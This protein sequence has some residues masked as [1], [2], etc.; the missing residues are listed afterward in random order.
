V[1]RWLCRVQSNRLYR[2]CQLN[3]KKK[4]G[5]QLW[6]SVILIKFWAKN[7]AWFFLFFNRPMKVSIFISMKLNVKMKWLQDHN[8]NWWVRIL[9][10]TS[11]SEDNY[12]PLPF[13]RINNGDIVLALKSSDI[14]VPFFLYHYS[15]FRILFFSIFCWNGTLLWPFKN[16]HRLDKIPIYKHPWTPFEHRWL[17]CIWRTIISLSQWHE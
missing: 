11:T 15:K 8:V 12:Y 9:T 16:G 7:F 17:L 2:K 4:H 3:A 1:V 5:I 6:L 14:Q 10:L 13:F